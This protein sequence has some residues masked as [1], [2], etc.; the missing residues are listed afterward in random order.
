[1]TTPTIKPVAS[2]NSSLPQIIQPKDQQVMVKVW[3]D[4]LD[5]LTKAHTKL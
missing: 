4:D 5:K 2:A 1:M 3:S